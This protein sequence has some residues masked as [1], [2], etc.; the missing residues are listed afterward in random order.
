MGEHS[1]SYCYG[2]Y[3]RSIMYES[4]NVQKYISGTKY[5]QSVLL[6]G[7]NCDLHPHIHEN[8]VQASS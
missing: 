2:A 5:A 3:T 1:H 7:L 4:T 6:M 8:F